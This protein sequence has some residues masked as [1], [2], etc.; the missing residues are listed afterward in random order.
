MLFATGDTE[1]FLVG[2]SFRKIDPMREFGNFQPFLLSH[3]FC[4]SCCGRKFKFKTICIACL[5]A[6]IVLSY[7]ICIGHCFVINSTHVY[8][9]PCL[10]TSHP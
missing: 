9:I 1:L 8:H 5:M 10:Q 4:D 3:A 7:F 2:S 6:C